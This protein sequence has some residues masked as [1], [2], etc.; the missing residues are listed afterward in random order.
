M[1]NKSL[2][3]GMQEV[4]GDFSAFSNRNICLYSHFDYEDM[5]DDYVFNAIDAIK[6]SGFEIVFIS[7]CQK[8]NR[9]DVE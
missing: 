9:S 7:T 3:P 8:L 1:T 5:V 2:L 6:N 4:F